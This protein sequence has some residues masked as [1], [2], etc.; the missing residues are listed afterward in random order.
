[1]SSQAGHTK[2]FTNANT[3][4]PKHF[5]PASKYESPLSILCFIF[6]FRLVS[7]QILLEFY[8]LVHSKRLNAVASLT[9]SKLQRALDFVHAD[10][11]FESVFR[12]E[13]FW[14]AI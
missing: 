6:D 5:V 14:F 4:H 7:M 9:L 10:D 11:R 8:Q 1:M 3:W 13:P 12:W 2:F